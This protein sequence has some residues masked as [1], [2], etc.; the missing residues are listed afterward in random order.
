MFAVIMQTMLS[1]IKENLTIIVQSYLPTY[2]KTMLIWC[3]CFSV[4]SML[5]QL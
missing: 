1:C 3:L 5:I 2:T 4:F